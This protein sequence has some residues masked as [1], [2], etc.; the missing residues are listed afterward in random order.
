MSNLDFWFV[1]DV[2]MDATNYRWCTWYATFDYDILLC[3]YG[4]LMSLNESVDVS[5]L[6]DLKMFELDIMI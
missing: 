2:D 4:D 6:I 5:M 1:N 3:M